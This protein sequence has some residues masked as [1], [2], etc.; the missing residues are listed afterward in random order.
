MFWIIAG[1]MTFVT[2][3]L[4][5]LPL[6]RRR[7]NAAAA[8][9][10]AVRKDYDLA[11]YR[12]QLRELDADLERGQIT[13]VQ[14]ASARIEIERRMLKAMDRPEGEGAHAVDARAERPVLA[15]LLAIGLPV[16]AMLLYTRLGSP[17]VPDHPFARHG[18]DRIV[19]AAKPGEKTETLEAL[20]EKLVDYLKQHPESAEGWMHLREALS[21]L[22]DNPRAAQLLADAV[23]SHPRD[24]E[25]RVTFGESLV[26]M[27]DGQVSPAARLVFEQ[28][29]TLDPRHPGV[30]YYLALGKFQRGEVEGAYNDWVALAKDSPPNAP[31]LGIVNNQIQTAAARLGRAAPMGSQAERA[32]PTAEQRAAIEAMNPADRDAMIRGMVQQLADRLKAQPGDYQGWIRLARAYAVLGDMKES[33]GALRQ[34]QKS[35]PPDLAASI[36]G[37]I[38]KLEASSK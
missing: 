22:G 10:Q 12:D 14:A 19:D 13:S 16:F 28:A 2:M 33:L 18:D 30:R 15:I 36:A 6:V 31:W 38:G 11:V 27:S 5:I 23:A 34:A 1:L 26:V 17:D 35:A 21:A 7:A 37:E 25:L 32:G 8:D 20:V 29:A 24:L 3:A 9:E 4:V